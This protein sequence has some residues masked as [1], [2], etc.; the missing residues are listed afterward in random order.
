MV[1][2]VFLVEILGMFSCSLVE[3]SSKCCKNVPKLKSHGT[4]KCNE[5]LPHYTQK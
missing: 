3:I 4:S 1:L 5:M 2:V